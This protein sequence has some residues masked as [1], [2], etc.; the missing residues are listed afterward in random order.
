[1]DGIPLIAIARAS[2]ADH[3]AAVANVGLVLAFQPL[4]DLKS[5]VEACE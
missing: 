3:R 5:Q 2:S 1:M 4:I